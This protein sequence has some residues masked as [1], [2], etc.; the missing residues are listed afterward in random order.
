MTGLRGG[1]GDPTLGGPR[2]APEDDGEDDDQGDGEQGQGNDDQQRL[3][4]ADAVGPTKGEVLLVLVAAVVGGLPLVV[5]SG[6][7]G[8][9]IGGQVGALGGGGAAEA[10]QR[11]DG[12]CGCVHSG[13]RRDPLRVQRRITG[14]GA[15]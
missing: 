3:Y 9:V 14:E 11:R 2:G 13:G 15:V 5:G 1:P 8:G 12:V 4:H 7:G 10:L 6:D